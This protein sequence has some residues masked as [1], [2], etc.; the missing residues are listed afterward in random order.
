MKKILT[1]LL[2]A[3]VLIIRMNI[4]SSA[5][6]ET[7]IAIC[8]SP[9]T[10][11]AGD[12]VTVTVSLTHYDAD[13]VPIEGIQID[14]ENVDDSVLTVEDGSYKTLIE[15][16]SN[17]CNEAVYQKVNQLLRL[18]FIKFTGT[19][20]RPYED[21]FEMTFLV[22]SELKEA[23]SI[24]LPVT[25]LFQT[26]EDRVTINDAFTISYVPAGGS[27]DPDIVSVDI[28]WGDMAY[29][30]TD[31][32]WNAGTHRYEGGGWSDSGTGYVEVCNTGTVDTTAVF[33]FASDREEISGSFTD[34]T[35]LITGPV[36]LNSGE[37][38]KA[39]LILSGR[40]SEDLSGEKIGTVTV[41]IGGE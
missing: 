11:E 36:A 13:A 4:V 28:S 15:D 3:A 39:G 6:E 34:G 35:D 1:F 17:I 2:L 24:T 5:K 14:V 31:G 41:Q 20:T 22:N 26:T 23:G 30:Y 33:T 29:T 16:D 27:T 10:A 19:L 21:I 37:S 25:A 40:P 38:E 18:L 12:Q 7:G 32:T 8:V 9:E